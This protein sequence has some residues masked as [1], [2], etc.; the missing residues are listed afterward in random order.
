MFEKLPGRLL[1]PHAISTE[2]SVTDLV[3]TFFLAYNAA[4][5]R[6]ACHLMTQHILQPG[7]TVGLTLSGA[8]TPT[9]L[10]SAAI[11]PLIEHGFVDWIVS[12]GAN[13]YHDL[14]RTL[15]HQLYQVAPST[16]D[17]ALREQRIIRIYDIVFEERVLLDTDEFLLHCLVLPEFQHRMSSAEFHARLGRYTL[18]RERTLGTRYCSIL[19]AAYKAGVPIYTS[20]PGDSTIGMNVA[21]L[22]ASGYEI[23]FD[24]E[25]DIL[26]TS[27]IVYH[28]KQQG[29]ESA[30]IICGGGSP[31]NFALQ[32]QPQLQEIFGIEES[33][34]DYFIQFTDARPDTG[35][36]SG[37]TP[38]EA[39]TW[40]KVNPSK[41]ANTVVCCTD[42]T[43]ALPIFTAYTLA[44][45]SP[46][47]L[48][49]LYELLGEHVQQLLSLPGVKQSV[50]EHVPYRIYGKGTYTSPRNP[51]VRQSPTRTTADSPGR[52]SP[53][54][55]DRG[56]CG[57]LLNRLRRLFS[58]PS[59]SYN[60]ELMAVRESEAVQS[61][62]ED[63]SEFPSQ[64]EEEEQED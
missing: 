12:T 8:L 51:P 26:E 7:V 27:A 25:A 42:V 60:Q 17:L 1:N 55:N 34:H 58:A 18:Q 61:F 28:A 20:S 16:D 43:I 40:G 64:E 47:P 53:S 48:K 13:L 23:G 6:E 57:R 11:V 3:D 41:L 54:G 49:R 33:G 39:V 5:L 56:G 52:R 29:G 35:G 4:R 32:T 19:S 50:T 30:I 38:Q 22:R 37:A 14:H 62:V 36:L 46:R 31:K 9:G 2:L 15:G 24:P 45:C 10:G 44:Q 59:Q 63:D 21:A